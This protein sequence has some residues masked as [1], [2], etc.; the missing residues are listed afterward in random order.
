MEKSKRSRLDPTGLRNRA[1]EKLLEKRANAPPAS[2]DADAKRLLHEM[3][4]TQIELEMQNEELRRA[5]DEL[6]A[7]R[8]AYV[9][10]FENA[11]VGYLILTESGLIVESNRTAGILLGVAG[12]AL[13]GRRLTD[14]IV[15]DDLDLYRG[16]RELLFQTGA[17]QTCEL[18]LS[19]ADGG[20]V[21]ATF[22]ATLAKD[23]EG[24]PVC[25]AAVSDVTARK[26]AEALRSRTAELE[27]AHAETEN[28]KRRLEAVMNALPV[29]VAIVDAAGAIVQANA[30]F[31]RVW[32]GPVPPMAS[33]ADYAAFRAW[34]PD[35]GRLVEPEEWA[36]AQCVKNRQRVENQLLVI[37]RF[38]GARAFVLNSAAPVHDAH[39]GIVGCTVAIGDVT[40]LRKAEDELRELNASLER[41][42]GERTAELER[43]AAQL[44]TL[45]V[46][47]AHAEDRERQRLAQVLH[48][49]LQQFLVAARF[50]ASSL[51]RSVTEPDLK[52]ES[53][54]LFELLG[55]SIEASRS[56]TI[57]LTPPAL[58]NENLLGALTWLAEWMRDTHGLEIEVAAPEA[59]IAL[60]ED[61][62]FVSFRAVRELLFNVVKHA[63]VKRAQVTVAQTADGNLRLVVADEGH[64]FDAALNAGSTFGLQSI[65]ERL[66]F[67][68]GELAI[69]SAPGRG[70]RATVTAPIA[71]GDESEPDEAA[72]PAAA[73]A[74]SPAPG[75]IRVL[76]AD[77]HAAIRQVIVELLRTTP[78]LAIVGEAA[79]GREVI[80]KAR[81]LRPQVLLMDVSMP[82]VSGID[83]TR[84]ISC[85]APDVR[86]IGLS[87]YAEADMAAQMRAAGAVGY[88]AKD[89]PIEELVKAIRNAA[90]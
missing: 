74:K 11:P 64:G 86:V 12:G 2:E 35:T 25:R 30:A 51:A 67:I 44:R 41:R 13:A 71:R 54:R 65:R 9:D 1:E 60:P 59:D 61:L 57:E 15:A 21:W 31:E 50:S 22:E 17:A 39:E 77:D 49:H 89:G 47:V 27:Q 85:Q 87:T 33:V 19:T 42:V 18:R 90:A 43:R 68:G 46:Q 81:Q 10:L 88:L 32:G 48:D 58:H 3:Q 76:V 28:A 37:E 4:V 83:A 23:D 55:K 52:A 38:D 24:A 53:Q 73:R 72:S 8:I 75:P 5:Q 26:E 36:A 14:F 82:L 69:D 70:T 29:G 78:G 66:A 6:S 16:H 40:D 79:D 63:G 56:L 62:R 84:I 34:W 20:R 80:E 7:S 45:A